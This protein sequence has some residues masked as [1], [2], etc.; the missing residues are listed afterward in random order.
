MQKSTK[1]KISADYSILFFICASLVL[2]AFIFDTPVQIIRNLYIINTSRSVLVTD[3]VELAGI[4]AAFVNVALTGFFYLILLR[5]NKCEVKGRIFASLFVAMGFSFFGKNLFNMLPIMFGVWLYA[6]IR[7]VKFSDLLVQAILSA[8]IAPV[9]S[10]IAFLNEVTTWYQI[11]V[12]YLVGMFVG[13]I[14]PAVAEAAKRMHRGYCLY[15]SGVA[16]GLISTLL[17]GLLRSAGINIIPEYLWSTS[18]TTLLAA[19]AYSMSAALIIYGIATDGPVNAYKKFKQLIN[20]KDVRESDFLA[21]YGNTCYINVG[22]MCIVGTSIMLLLKIPINGPVLGGIFTISGF[23]ASGKHLKNSVPIL[24]GS[25]IA[26]LLNH[27]ELASPMNSLAIL[28][29]TGLAPISGKHGWICGIIVGFLHVSVAIF[30]GNL[31]G[32]LNLYNNGFAEGFI[33]ITTVPL[34]VFFK[35]TF[36]RKKSC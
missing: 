25:V 26:S 27:F 17:V 9:V 35:E 18:Q 6:K 23:S 15:N 4:G 32:G 22:I 33:A 7:R 28:F 1:N 36:G 19:F 13:F 20:E 21:K 30:I 8:T 24:L 29:S 10:E 16:G 5:T 11:V 31:N 14:F 3:Y 12:A 34:I 2:L